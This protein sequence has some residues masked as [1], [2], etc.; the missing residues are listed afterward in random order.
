MS[1]VSWH[2]AIF[3]LDKRSH[4]TKNSQLSQKNSQLSQKNS[5]LSQ[6]NS[7]LYQKKRICA[8]LHCTADWGRQFASRTAHTVGFGQPEH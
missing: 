7:Q 2:I 1:A 4:S 3:I 5:Q 6:K 8:V